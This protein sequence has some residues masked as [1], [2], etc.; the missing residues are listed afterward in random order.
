MNIADNKIFMIFRKD[1]NG[2]P[3][4]S[5]G[6]SK[7]NQ[8]GGYDKGYIQC[9]FK[10]DVNLENQ[11]KIYIKKAWISF[12]LK[13]KET[14]PFIFISEFETIGQTIDRIHKENEEEYI[15]ENFGTSITAEELDDL[16]F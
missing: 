11:T 6:I 14:K 9:Q 16:P 15:K 4:Y 5:I 13:E 10:K 1:Y 7:K 3:L 2:K 12:Y 8:N